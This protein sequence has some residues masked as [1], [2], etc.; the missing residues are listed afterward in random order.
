MIF[1]C[2]VTDTACLVAGGM[3]LLTLPAAAPGRDASTLADPQA[4]QAMAVAASVTPP[5]HATTDILRLAGEYSYGNGFDL[6]CTLVLS[7]DGRF[8]Y[9]RCDCEVVVEEVVGRAALKDG[10]LVL[11][12]EVPRKSWPSGMHGVMIPVTWGQRLYLLPQ[13]DFLGFSNQVNRGVE[14]ISTGSMG[15]YF[16][17]EGDWDRPADGKPSLPHEWQQ[18]LLEHPVRGTMTGK[19]PAGRWMINLGKKHGVYDGMELSAWAPDLRQ[20][21][22]INVVET[23]AESSAVSVERT[24]SRNQQLTGW[25]VYSRVVPPGQEKKDGEK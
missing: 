4:R 2:L 13:D 25:I 17:R 18:R 22:T 14:P 21:V 6:N 20:F 5:E 24:Q 16:L 12:A 8:V 3:L 7:P 10:E 11:E 1:R 23:G 19:D 15:R 9:K